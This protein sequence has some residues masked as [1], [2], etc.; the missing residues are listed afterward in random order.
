MPNITPYVCR[1][2]YRS[3]RARKGMNPETPQY[4]MDHSDISV[5]MNMYTH[6]E[7]DDAAEE[8]KRPDYEKNEP[9]EYRQISLCGLGS[10][11]QL[12]G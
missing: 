4:L 11:R 10:A 5:T 1:H 3:N 9:G 12:N 8:V 6:S 2:T 7:P